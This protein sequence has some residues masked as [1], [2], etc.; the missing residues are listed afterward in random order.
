M[1]LKKKIAI[2][3]IAASVNLFANGLSNI[4]TLVDQINNTSE[5]KE[6]KILMKKLDIELAVIDKK[7]VPKAKEI[8]DTKLKK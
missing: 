2:F 4:S 3:T 7:Y 6:K 8:I 1:K 5:I